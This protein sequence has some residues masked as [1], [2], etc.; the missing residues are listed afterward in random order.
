V[1]LFILKKD[2]VCWGMG[3][4]ERCSDRDVTALIACLD[5]GGVYA[6]DGFGEAAE[7]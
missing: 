7:V 3:A 2:G 5:H 6:W 1:D 4:Y